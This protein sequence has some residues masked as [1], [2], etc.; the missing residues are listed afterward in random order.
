MSG[1]KNV[2]NFHFNAKNYKCWVPVELYFLLDTWYSSSSF[3][4]CQNRIITHCLCSLFHQ[5]SSFFRSI[6]I[7]LNITWKE[8]EKYVKIRS[9]IKYSR[10]ILNFH[11]RPLRILY[12]L[13]KISLKT[14]FRA[15]HFI[16]YIMEVKYINFPSI[17]LSLDRVEYHNYQPF[18]FWN[19]NKFTI[20]RMQLNIL[21]EI[22]WMLTVAYSEI[23]LYLHWPRLVWMFRHL[24]LEPTEIWNRSSFWN[25]FHHNVYFIIDYFRFSLFTSI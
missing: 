7:S 17:I 20:N 1:L 23:I 15:T 18:L 19:S 5:L 11:K 9:F 14:P 2:P 8:K 22:C 13:L 16:K 25:N 3:I 24:N 6:S 12:C 4:L 10:I 21:L